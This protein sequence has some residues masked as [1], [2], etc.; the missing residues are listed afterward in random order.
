MIVMLSAFLAVGFYG[1]IHSHPNNDPIMVLL[2]TCGFTLLWLMIFFS[3]NATIQTEFHYDY[4]RG[5]PPLIKP[6]VRD[7]LQARGIYGI[8]FN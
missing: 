5:C 2:L 3:F 6:E 1:L 8:G 4:Y 7:I